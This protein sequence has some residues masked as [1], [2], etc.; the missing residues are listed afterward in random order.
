MD[1]VKIALIS[2]RIAL[3]DPEY[4]ATVLAKEAALAAED[5]AR[6]IAFPELA[7]TGATAGD[8][9]SQEALTDAA[10]AALAELCH[11]IPYEI[12]IGV[13]NRVPRMYLK[14]GQVV[15]VVDGLS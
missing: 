3:C 1:K 11:T 10:D 13:G 8:L 12:L 9:Y 4:N 14:G 15:S 2:P 5:G 7:L 6:V